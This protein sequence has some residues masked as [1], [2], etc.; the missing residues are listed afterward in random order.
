[1]GLH[2][3]P[4]G[5]RLSRSGRKW[6]RRE[7][8]EAARRRP[9][10]VARRRVVT[11]R[12]GCPVENVGAYLRALGRAILERVRR[13]GVGWDRERVR[14]LSRALGHGGG[15]H[16]VMPGQDPIL[17]GGEEGRGGREGQLRRQAARRD[18]TQ[19]MGFLPLRNERE[20]T[21]HPL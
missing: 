15:C 1:M 18:K 4:G 8:P 12:H 14:G 5:R 11:H 6:P 13:G 19:R 7:C 9:E 20:N 17:L 16:P 10:A 2:S 21:A 3:L